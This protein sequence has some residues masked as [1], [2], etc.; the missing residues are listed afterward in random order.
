MHEV[1]IVPPAP[2]LCS[3]IEGAHGGNYWLMNYRCYYFRR[4]DLGKSRCTPPIDSTHDNNRTCAAGFGLPR[5]QGI[6]ASV[7]CRYMA[8]AKLSYSRLNH[9]VL[10]E[11]WLI[12]YFSGMRRMIT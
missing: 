6:F 3:S 8:Q 1:C 10:H 4:H 7:C 12:A 2:V 9:F 5:V 11:T